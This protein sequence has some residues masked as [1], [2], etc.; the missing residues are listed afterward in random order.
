[1]RTASVLVLT[2]GLLAACAGVP[3][4]S[5]R[6]W[7]VSNRDGS[8]DRLERLD[9][10][11]PIWEVWTAPDV[12]ETRVRPVYRRIE[13][14]DRLLV[15]I[16]WPIFVLRNEPTRNS[17]TILP[18]FFSRSLHD[19]QGWDD[20]DWGLIPV[21][22][23]GSDPLEGDY[24]LFFPFWGNLRG[25]LGKDEM[26][27]RFFPLYLDTRQGEY[28][29][30]HLLWPIVSWGSGEGRE[31]FRILPFYSHRESEGKSHETS[32][33]WPLVSWGADGLDTEHPSENVLVFP[34]YGRVESDVVWSQ[35]WM[36]PAYMASGAEGGY[37]DLNLLWPV[38]RSRTGPDGP[39]SLR[40]WPL[41]SRT[42]EGENR[43]DW[44]LWPLIWDSDVA[45]GEG[46]T[47]N[48]HFVPFYRRTERTAPDGT[49]RDSDLQV[50]PLFRREEGTDGSVHL[51]A[52]AP[53][54]FTNLESFEAAWGWSWSL[55]DHVSA[56]GGSSTDLLFG[57][58]QFRSSAEGAY[59]GIPLLLEYAR[60]E[61]ASKVHLVKGLLGYEESEDG[62]AIR[63]LWLL[64]IGL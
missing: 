31:D 5:N 33:I 19:E 10:L 3:D 36:F 25:Q 40:I 24:L 46:R 9:V 26:N 63:L 7:P 48:F 38:F 53:I 37:L 51:R 15:E 47:T 62:A 22:L 29:S 55:L 56:P 52:L 18:L 27:F 57:L 32:V 43:D 20:S 58:V 44:Y 21:L 59:A 34:F 13:A 30:T 6:A 49:F 60:R 45:V 16:L 1:M 8:A 14:E 11:W 23:G 54:P 64:R 2:L 35:I 12:T 41:F 4:T 50:W 42:R 17:L 39:Q 28:E 61:E